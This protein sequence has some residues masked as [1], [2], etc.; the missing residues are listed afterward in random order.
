MDTV[1][2]NPLVA[3]VVIALN[4]L[5]ECCILIFLGGI[6]VLNKKIPLMH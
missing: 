2:K 5:M 6:F 4:K 3:R 1:K